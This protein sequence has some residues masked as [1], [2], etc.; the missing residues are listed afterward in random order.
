MNP[1]N[2]GVTLLNDRAYNVIRLLAMVWIPAIQAA[3]FSIAQLW[4]FSHTEA[5]VGTIAVLNVLLGA[6]AGVSQKVYNVTGAKYDGTFVIKTNPEDSTTSVVISVPED[7]ASWLK[8]SEIT[9]KAVD[10]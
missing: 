10:K 9:F 4:G 7:A 2:P 1:S 3:Y 8:K 5:I 6:I